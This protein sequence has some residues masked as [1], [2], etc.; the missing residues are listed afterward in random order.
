MAEDA[1]AAVGVAEAFGGLL[2]GQVIDE[3]SA[4]GF[5]L[6]VCGTGRDEER[7]G[8]ACYLL[9]YTVI[10]ITTISS[11]SFL[12]R[13]ICCGPVAWRAARRRYAQ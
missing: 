4:E 7:A 11:C 13:P 10:H 3:E 5:V 2:G 12:S 8:E 1:E 9:S 6:A